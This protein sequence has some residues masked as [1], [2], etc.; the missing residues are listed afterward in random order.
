MIS[1]ITL[2][3]LIISPFR[4]AFTDIDCIEL[5]IFEMSMDIAFM[6]DIALQFFIPFYNS[7]EDLIKNKAQIA[8][9]YLTSWFFFDLLASIPGSLISFI[10]NQNLLLLNQKDVSTDG[11]STI[12]KITRISKLYKILKFTKLSKL[13]KLSSGKNK[14]KGKT[15]PSV[16]DFNV[17]SQMKRLVNFFIVFILI[18]HIITCF[19]IFLGFSSYPNWILKKGLIDASTGDLYIASLYFHWTTIF[20][21]GYGDILSANTMERLYNNILMFIGVLVYSFAVSSLGTIVSSYDGL[22]EK[23]MKNMEQ[24]QDIS[25]RYKIPDEFNDKVY[26]YL[27]Y[28]LKFNKKEKFSFINELPT[29]LKNNLLI[30]M[31]REVIRNFRFLNENSRE[32]TS[33]VVFMMKPLRMYFKEYIIT[34]GEFLE[35]VIF[36][37]HG[38]MSLH[39]GKYYE[40]VKLMEVRKNEHFGDILVLSNLR[41]P[42]TI[43]IGSKSCDLLIIKKQDLLEIAADFPESI[44]EIFLISSF[45]YSSLMDIIEYKKRKI[46]VQR[47]IIKNRK[48]EFLKYLNINNK[49]KFENEIS[50]F[51]IEIKDNNN[52]I[53]S[54]K[55]NE[56]LKELKKNNI[57]SNHN[58][59][60]SKSV[61]KNNYNNRN[62][63]NSKDNEDTNKISKTFKKTMKKIKE[64][65][66]IKV[67][68][69]DKNRNKNKNKD[70]DI[71]KD[72]YNH[73]NNDKEKE[74]SIENLLDDN[75]KNNEFHD[76]S[77]NNNILKNSIDI[78]KLNTNKNNNNNNNNNSD[79]DNEN[80]YN[81]KNNQRNSSSSINSSSSDIIE[82][83]SNKE[84][85]EKINLS[86]SKKMNK[87]KVNDE[88]DISEIEID[89]D[90]NNNCCDNIK[91]IAFDDNKNFEIDDDVYIV[92]N[93]NNK[94][95]DD[96]NKEKNITLDVKLNQN[97]NQDHNQ[98]QHNNSNK[99]LFKSKEQNNILKSKLSSIKSKENKILSKIK[100]INIPNKEKEK[101]NFNNNRNSVEIELSSKKIIN[102]KINSGISNNFYNNNPYFDNNLNINNKD[103]TKNYSNDND[104]Y[105]EHINNNNDNNYNDDNICKNKCI[106]G[107]DISTLSINIIEGLDNNHNMKVKKFSKYSLNNF[108][109]KSL[110]DKFNFNIEKI[111]EKDNDNSEFFKSNSEV[112]SICK[113]LIPNKNNSFF[114]I[115]DEDENSLNNFSNK[116]N[117]NSKNED[118]IIIKSE[119]EG[120]KN[121]SKSIFNEINSNVK[122]KIY[123]E[124]NNFNNNIIENFND[125]DKD[126]NNNDKNNNNFIYNNEIIIEEYL[127]K[128]DKKIIQCN[129]C[130]NLINLNNKENKKIIYLNKISSD[131]DK[132]ELN[133]NKTKSV[134]NIFN[135]C[136]INKNIITFRKKEEKYQ[137][138]ENK[139]KKKTSKKNFEIDFDS[140]KE[141]EKIEEITEYK[142]YFLS[143]T[144]ENFKNKQK[145]LR[146]N[147]SLNL[148]KSKKICHAI[149]DSIFYGKKLM[150]DP[151]AF[152]LKEFQILFNS[153]LK[154]EVKN[155]NKLINSLLI[156]ILNLKRF[157]GKFEFFDGFDKIILKN[158]DNNNNKS[159]SFDSVFE[160]SDVDIY[161]VPYFN[162]ENIND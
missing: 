15:V 69:K 11:L 110:F 97:N 93:C 83:D 39:L 87:L 126:N 77:I 37:R 68:K 51:E 70:E 60:I 31:Y 47:E 75:F 127:N 57:L 134:T 150:N 84:N 133:D 119:I 139:N 159:E 141:K 102:S 145:S 18:S 136:Q 104:N 131:L 108:E 66:E 89:I 152:Y 154:E 118:S 88:F 56:N 2:Y 17:N 46:E 81:F 24:L 49:N 101:D 5:E 67:D 129:N 22:T 151:K 80:Y 105:N 116:D 1:L 3:T 35:E 14:S 23:F 96:N 100:E 10:L 143:K 21:I 59:I 40:E 161:D 138:K 95:N 9:H 79:N 54:K 149:K 12:N 109:D 44:E 146:I 120:K 34:E 111:I 148:K 13:I 107:K 114:K 124:N 99:N 62:S 28:D 162:E 91:N 7:E 38:Y 147:D 33:K 41:S 92:D 8:K 29:R 6:L 25:Y 42:V 30:N 112:N 158:N 117:K 20:T 106:Q 86:T 94:Y 156:K 132:I 36:V 115:S 90:N 45:N 160:N 135:N 61:T 50:N 113:E 122:R 73:N 98:N 53:K 130:K 121:R 55:T 48:I 27:R 72:T 71:N 137:N 58:N 153:G 85:N 123:N 32:F 16:E 78:E 43:K 65:E 144:K 128:N 155:E 103:K 125:K 76:N 63:E 52:K 142:K 19:W 157:E 64:I 140:E 26:K 82:N 4:L 74:S